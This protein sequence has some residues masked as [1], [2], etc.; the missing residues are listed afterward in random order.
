M[1]RRIAAWLEPSGLFL[2][3]TRHRAWTG[4][5]EDWLGGGEPMWWSHADAGAYRSW[6]SQAGLSIER[7]EFVP[8]GDEGDK[9]HALFWATKPAPA[10]PPDRYPRGG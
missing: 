10:G 7:E 4:V 3:T 8:E 5:E 9:G 1:L 6:I 2:A